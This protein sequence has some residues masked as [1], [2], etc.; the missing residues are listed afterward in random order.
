[1]VKKCI[2]SGE[3]P[4]LGKDPGLLGY[5]FRIPDRAIDI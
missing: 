3:G 4:G 5:E 1:M 2:F